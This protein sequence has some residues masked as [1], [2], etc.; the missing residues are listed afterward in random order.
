MLRQRSRDACLHLVVTKPPLAALLGHGTPGV[1][2]R[3]PPTKSG[4]RE[5]ISRPNR[6]I[7]MYLIAFSGPTNIF[8]PRPTGNVSSLSRWKSLHFAVHGVTGE[9]RDCLDFD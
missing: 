2:S 6:R 5:Q 4:G 1:A 8:F 9:G 7:L 3:I